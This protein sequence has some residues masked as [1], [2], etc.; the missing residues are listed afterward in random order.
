MHLVCVS[1]ALV[2]GVTECVTCNGTGYC[3]QCSTQVC[4]D[5]T[6]WRVEGVTLTDCH[7]FICGS[8]FTSYTVTNEKQQ[9]C[10]RWCELCFVRCDN[11]PGTSACTRARTWT[12]TWTW[13]NS[14][15]GTT[16]EESREDARH[17]PHPQ[18]S[19]PN[20]GNEIDTCSAVYS[21]TG[22]ITVWHI[23]TQVAF[24]P[25]VFGVRALK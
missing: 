14:R 1:G 10:E 13:T 16:S 6:R 20:Y 21:R 3:V 22:P 11:S 24:Q 5:Y 15:G 9:Y 12:W 19:T 17:D 25:T 2:W 18:Q 7:L 8:F 23:N 4:E